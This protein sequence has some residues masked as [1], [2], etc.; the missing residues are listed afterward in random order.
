MYNK[1]Q[2]L[3][4]VG[5]VETKTLSNGIQATNISMVTTIKTKNPEKPE[6]STWHKVVLY[7]KLAEI[8][9]KYVNPGDL[10]EVHGEM[11]VQKYTGSDG[12]EKTRFFVLAHQIFLLPNK[13]DKNDGVG[14]EKQPEYSDLEDSIP[15]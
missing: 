7:N 15:F 13:R 14:N 2:I 11:E 12:I 10:L 8:A 9:D 4:R 3:G 5:K 1:A 6:K